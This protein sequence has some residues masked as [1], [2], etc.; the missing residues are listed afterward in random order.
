[1]MW[2]LCLPF[3]VRKFSNKWPQCIIYITVLLINIWMRSATLQLKMTFLGLTCTY[4]GKEFLG[5]FI[6]RV[7]FY[8]CEKYNS[9]V[10]FQL[11]YSMSSSKLYDIPKSFIHHW[12]SGDQS[13]TGNRWKRPKKGLH[14]SWKKYHDFVCQSAA[15]KAQ[16]KL[17]RSRITA[18]EVC[19]LI[20]GAFTYCLAVKTMNLS[21]TTYLS[22]PALIPG[23]TVHIHLIPFLKYV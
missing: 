9:C 3:I 19:R 23:Y 5:H 2:I 8:F 16:S 12:N 20:F 14:V 22:P 1:M 21:Y 4:R 10:L 15:K 11:S 18:S 6:F 13:T 7:P 17:T